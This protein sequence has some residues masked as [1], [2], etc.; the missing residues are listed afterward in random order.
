[1]CSELTDVSFASDA[2]RLV[3]VSE[4]RQGADSAERD[5]EYGVPFCAQSPSV[6]ARGFVGLGLPSVTLPVF[7]GMVASPE[8]VA[9]GGEVHK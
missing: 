7:S 9:S 3:A 8:S 6:L 2:I 4:W 5:S 1:M